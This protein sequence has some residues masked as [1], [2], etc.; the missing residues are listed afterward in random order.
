VAVLEGAAANAL[1][2]QETVLDDGWIL[3]ADGV[4]GV[5][6]RANA[7]LPRGAGRDPLSAKLARAE[8]WYRARGRAPRF[9]VAPDA[10]PDGVVDALAAAGY[11]FEVPV[12]VLV[13]ALEPGAAW[14]LEGVARA[15][16]PDAAWRAAYAATL[17]ERERAERLR[18]AVAA[19]GPKVYAA[20]GTDGCGLAVC[21]GD[22]VGLFDVATAPAARRR[23]I[24]RRIT[25]ALLGWG[26]D[27]G[28]RRAYLQVAEGNAAARALYA[29]FGFRPAYRYVYA[30][31]AS[32]AGGADQ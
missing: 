4:Q 27:A 26:Q 28:A 23:G 11:R 29:T 3:R 1:R 16:A 31:P 32:A 22:W 9:L 15:A 13:R 30:V 25:A 2:A 10:A 14:G 20:V 21:S 7:V 19:P 17:P 5:V 24:A 18:L 6:R 8:A 12:L